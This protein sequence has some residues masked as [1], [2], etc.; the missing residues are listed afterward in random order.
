[1]FDAQ[2]K[3]YMGKVFKDVCKYALIY[4]NKLDAL[5]I[6]FTSI[7]SWWYKKEKE[8]PKL[9]RHIIAKW[10]ISYCNWQ[11]QHAT[12]ENKVEGGWSVLP[13]GDTWA[14]L[15]LAHD[16]Y[17]LAHCIDLSK[18][19]INRLRNKNQF[20]GVR[21]EIAIAATFVRADYKI[22]Y[23]KTKGDKS[24]EFIAT[25]KETGEKI[26]VEVK[27]RHRPGVLHHNGEMQSIES[28]KV[29]ISR[30]LNQ[31][32]QQKPKNIPFVISIDLNLPPSSGTSLED[33]RWLNDLKQAIS[34]IGDINISR[35][36]EFTALFITNYSYHYESNLP[37]NTGTYAADI[38]TI[39][40]KY[41]KHPF[42]DPRTLRE[43]MA[44]VNTYGNVPYEWDDSPKGVFMNK[45]KPKI[46][47]LLTCGLIEMKDQLLRL[48]Q[49][50]H[51]IYSKS[52]TG[53]VDLWIYVEGHWFPP[54]IH[55]LK[56]TM[57]DDQRKLISNP[58]PLDITV[59]ANGIFEAK[60]LLE[61]HIPYKKGEYEIH[62]SIAGAEPAITQ[63][64]MV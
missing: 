56:I 26:G 23:L 36:E 38:I 2:F 25:H 18:D 19:L 14:L 24:C 22:G 55:Q 33:K 50:G 11:K 20:Q 27:S 43:L 34:N 9:E 63:I 29:G 60:L 1:M 10:Y 45:R 37:I 39:I 61:K 48:T 32:I 44:T 51:T 21:Y 7:G 52:G 30:M 6:S 49:V 54:G 64:F 46:T 13:S 3:K 28:V 41:I 42:K 31:A 59:S 35:P 53:I 17:C 8:K 57:F 12:D 4:F 16:L 40:P 62:A 58:H 5:P 47:A 15:T